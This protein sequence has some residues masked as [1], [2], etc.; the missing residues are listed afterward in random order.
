MI[1]EIN[2]KKLDKV[3]YISFDVFDTLIIRNVEKTRD[4]FALTEKICKKK[5]INIIDNFVD[6]RINVDFD[7][8]SQKNGCATIDD[9]YNALKQRYNCDLEDVKEIEIECE[10]KLCIPNK[11]ICEIYNECKRLGKKII[12]ISDMYLPSDV[13]SFMLCKCGID[14]YDKLY[15]SCEIGATK[16]KGDLFEFVLRD[17]GVGSKEVFHIGDNVKGDYIIPRLKG[18]RSYKVKRNNIY[19][20][21]DLEDRTWN[22]CANN[23]GIDTNEI[24]GMGAKYFGP[25]L[26]GFS[27]WLSTNIE[28]DNI[29]QVFFLARDGYTIK[30][31]FDVLNNDDEMRV[32]THYLYCSRRAFTV[33]LIWQHAELEKIRDNISFSHRMGVKDFLEKVG[34]EPEKY[35]DIAQKYKIDA[36]I[37]YENFELFSQPMFMQFYEEIKEDILINSEQEF[38]ALR[39]YIQ[40]HKIKGRI[41]VVDIGY[42]GTM[43]NALQQ[44]L[45]IWGIDAEVYGYYVLLDASSNLIKNRK[46]KA[47]GYLNQDMDKDYYKLIT[48]FTPVFES[49]FLATEGSLKKFVNKSN[50]IE[51]I[52]YENE[53]EKSKESFDKMKI[54]QSGAYSFCDSDSVRFLLETFGGM[55]PRNAIR[56]Y[57]KV[58]TEPNLREAEF[59]GDIAFFEDSVRY[60]AKPKRSIYY[61]NHIKAVYYDLKNCLWKIGFVKRLIRLPLKYGNLIYKMR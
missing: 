44:L 50:H 30:K 57:I 5:N 47:K 39:D 18:I 41:A 35:T 22:I 43:Q 3:K 15:V 8:Q 4:I 9:I 26:A 52:F 20:D 38:A 36:N 10:T 51:K 32:R 61:L 2:R 23:A 56:N 27:S 40:S 21:G 1:G 42:H 29:D 33:P 48:L 12:I 6:R 49:A 59:W 60:I 31:A 24:R 34:L 28:S 17:L 58:G 19:I 14:T 16:G 45:E 54:Y 53:Y 37:V 55:R 46:I 13:I 7:I 11:R 25:L